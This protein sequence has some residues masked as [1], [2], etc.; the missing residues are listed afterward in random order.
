MTQIS[1]DEAV[2]LVKKYNVVLFHQEA[3]INCSLVRLNDEI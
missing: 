3:E 1:L 2:D